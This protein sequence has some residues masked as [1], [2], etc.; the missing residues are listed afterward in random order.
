MDERCWVHGSLRLGF[1]LKMERR[2]GGSRRVRQASPTDPGCMW[3][4]GDK[5]R[6]RGVVGG[7]ESVRRG[8]FGK[9]ESMGLLAEG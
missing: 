1:V 2:R 7:W 6:C 4:T 8:A 5:P 3:T 9:E